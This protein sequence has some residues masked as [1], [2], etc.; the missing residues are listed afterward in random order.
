MHTYRIRKGENTPNKASAEN[1]ALLAANP[2][3]SPLVSS[4][5]KSAV[6]ELA[7]QM[8]LMMKKIEKLNKRMKPQSASN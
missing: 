6:D 8:Q 1:A 3:N 5:K 4:E 2:V 7:E